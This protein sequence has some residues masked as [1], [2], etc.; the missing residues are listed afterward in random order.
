MNQRNENNQRHG[1][2]EGYYPNGQL[3]WKGNCINDMRHGYW[4]GYHPNGK[5]YYKENYFNGQQIGFWINYY[6][7]YFYL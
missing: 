2:W 6:K 1:Y 5:V 4:E 7:T 3:W